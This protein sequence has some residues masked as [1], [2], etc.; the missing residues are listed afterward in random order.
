MKN[1]PGQITEYQALLMASHSLT[2]NIWV[3]QSWMLIHSEIQH[4]FVSYLSGYMLAL[5]HSRSSRTQHHLAVCSFICLVCSHRIIP[6]FLLSCVDLPCTSCSMNVKLGKGWRAPYSTHREDG[7]AWW[8]FSN[9][10]SVQLWTFL[11]F[12][13]LLWFYSH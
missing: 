6:G 8:Q 12:S 4:W 9:L 7:L 3:L 1:M 13:C 10:I 5:H 11:A 2:D